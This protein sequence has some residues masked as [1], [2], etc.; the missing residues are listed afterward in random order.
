[1]TVDDVPYG[2]GGGMVLKPEPIFRAV[3]ALLAGDG[4]AVC[5]DF[6][7]PARETLPQE[8]AE[9]LS[10]EPVCSFICGHY[11]GYDERIRRV[12]WDHDEIFARRLCADRRRIPAM[13]VIDSVVRLC[14][15]CLATLIRLLAIRFRR[16]AG[17]SA[18]YP[19][20]RVSRHESAGYAAFRPS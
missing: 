15:A 13:A 10:E 7:V 12:I 1:M 5:D 11:E 4:E 16:P 9:E 2:G 14:R 17:V 20:D 3:E 19:T 8:K 6:N 18:I